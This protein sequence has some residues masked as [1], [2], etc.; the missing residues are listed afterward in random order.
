MSTLPAWAG[1]SETKPAPRPLLL[2]QVFVNSR[3]G[4]TGSDVLASQ[5]TGTRWLRAAGLAGPSAGV[6]AAALRRAREIRESLRVLIGSNGGG[7]PPAGA[8][9]GP[10]AAPARASRPRLSVGQ[11][12]QIALGTGLD[13]TLAGGL[14]GLLLIV[15]DA[16]RDGTWARLKICRNQECRRAFYDR[17]HAHRGTWCDM[18]TCGNMIKNRNFRARRRS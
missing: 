1:A 13:A 18:A 15:R 17:S 14:A 2:V 12:G 4:I 6:S 3:D 8:D 5:D 7:P 16:Q 9:L 10:L 11:D